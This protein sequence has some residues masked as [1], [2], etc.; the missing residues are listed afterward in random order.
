MLDTHESL[1]RIPL[2]LKINYFKIGTLNTY[3]KLQRNY[4]LRYTAFFHF[5]ELKALLLILSHT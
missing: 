3:H 2:P 5:N 1:S 4:I